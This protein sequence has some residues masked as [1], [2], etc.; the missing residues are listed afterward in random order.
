M[1][2]SGGFMLR[3]AAVSG[4]HYPDPRDLHDLQ[5]LTLSDIDNQRRNTF[6]GLSVAFDAAT[7]EAAERSVLEC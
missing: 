6:W 2:G 1:V 4:D 3:R 7:K 5:D